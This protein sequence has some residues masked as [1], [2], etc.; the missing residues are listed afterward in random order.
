V[1]VIWR[2]TNSQYS[3][4]ALDDELLLLRASGSTLEQI[5]IA[6]ADGAQLDRQLAVLSSPVDYAYARGTAG[7]AYALVMF[8]TMSVLGRVQMNVFTSIAQ[9]ELAIAGP[10]G[11]GDGTLLALDGKLMQLIE[12]GMRP[13]ADSAPVLC[14]E[15]NAGLSYACNPDGIAAVSGQAL[16]APLFRLSWLLAPDLERL[17][18]GEPRDDCSA[19]WRDLRVDLLAVG[20]A[21]VEDV[22][23]D[24]GGA[25]DAGSTP[26][27]AAIT[28][29]GVEAREAAL[30]DGGQEAAPGSLKRNSSCQVRLGQRGLHGQNVISLALALLLWRIR[31]RIF[32]FVHTNR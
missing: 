17:S 11:A 24:P 32:G 14:L 26:L 5:T 23:S 4:A 9:A 6:A 15:Q 1:R 13:L 25:L 21:L 19:Q 28:G 20:I 31:R 16:G 2:D 3:L 8:R 30:G 27:D 10:L 7:S 29:E 22:Q 12:G 18:P